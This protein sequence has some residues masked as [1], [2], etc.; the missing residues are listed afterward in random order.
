MHMQHTYLN[1]NNLEIW[2]KARKYCGKKHENTQLWIAANA[3]KHNAQ[4]MS[5]LTFET[6]MLCNI[7]LCCLRN[8]D[9]ALSLHQLELIQIETNASIML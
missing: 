1:A 8:D 9:E 6:E 5:T 2:H 7:R 4:L 3:Y